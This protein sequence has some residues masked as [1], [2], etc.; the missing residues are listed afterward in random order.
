MS[1]ALAPVLSVARWKRS[2]K[3]A[4][5]LAEPIFEMSAESTTGVPTVALV[6]VTF[7]AVRSEAETVQDAS[8][9]HLPHCSVAL[10]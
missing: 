4:T 10:K 6:F 2:V 7:P 9:T 8:G 5:V 3:A 1:V